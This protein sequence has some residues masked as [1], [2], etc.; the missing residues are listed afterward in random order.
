M[1]KHHRTATKPQGYGGWT[2]YPNNIEPL[3]R[4][5]LSSMLWA[6]TTAF[7]QSLVI[8]FLYKTAN[9]YICSLRSPIQPAT[10]FFA[11]VNVQPKLVATTKSRFYAAVNYKN[12]H[13]QDSIY[14]RLSKT[15]LD[16]CFYHLVHFPLA[17]SVR[18]L[19]HRF[20]WYSNRRIDFFYNNLI[21]DYGVSNKPVIDKE[22]FK[23]SIVEVRIAGTILPVQWPTKCSCRHH[24]SCVARQFRTLDEWAQ[25]PFKLHGSIQGLTVL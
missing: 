25:E 15:S 21:F 12:L 7:H 22:K 16:R 3:T 11:Y 10:G 5:E 4:I 14:T 8:S 2:G 1:P 23:Y 6:N 13:P 18:K 20:N 17:A 24:S 19:R 9:L